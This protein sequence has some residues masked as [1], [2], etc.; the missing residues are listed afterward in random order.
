M[1]LLE[2]FVNLKENFD[3]IKYIENFEADPYWGDTSNI[4]DSWKHKDGRVY[5]P[6]LEYDPNALYDDRE[7]N[8]TYDYL[9]PLLENVDKT[10]TTKYTD[11]DA[12]EKITDNEEE[13]EEECSDNILDLSCNKGFKMMIWGLILLS[14]IFFIILIVFIARKFMSDSTQ[15]SSQPVQTTEQSV[16]SVQPIQP[17]QPMQIEEPNRQNVFGNFFKPTTT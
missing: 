7:D 14:L 10:K 6:K 3:N 16:Q 17:V 9:K 12:K 8:D 2:Y 11:E 13:D 5:D 15:I 4:P 1:N